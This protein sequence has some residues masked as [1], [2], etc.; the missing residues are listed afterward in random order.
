M[1]GLKNKDKEV[2]AKVE[3]TLAERDESIRQAFGNFDQKIANSFGSIQFNTNV[4]F[5]VFEKLGVTENQIKE[6]ADEV[7]L[8]VQNANN[9]QEVTTDEQQP[10][11]GNATEGDVPGPDP[12]EGGQ[13]HF[14]KD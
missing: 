12:D 6:I 11:D 5:A 14:G 2:L 3:A 4:I 1:A 8:K 7:K 10:Y 9:P 13:E